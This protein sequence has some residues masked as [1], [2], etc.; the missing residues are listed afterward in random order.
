MRKNIRQHFQQMIP[1]LKDLVGMN[2]KLTGNLSQSLF[3]F[4][5]FQGDFCLE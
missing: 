3:P 4:H 2:P 1:S 5:G